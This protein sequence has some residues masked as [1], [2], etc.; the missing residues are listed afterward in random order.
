MNNWR[1]KRGINTT[2]HIT[3]TLGNKKKISIMR[4]FASNGVGI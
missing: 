2:L 4:G 3:R 1:M